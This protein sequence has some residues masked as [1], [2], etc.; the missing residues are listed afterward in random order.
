MEEASALANKVGII[1]KQLLGKPFVVV[2][3]RS[4]LSRM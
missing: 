4:H 3:A 1:S 2:F